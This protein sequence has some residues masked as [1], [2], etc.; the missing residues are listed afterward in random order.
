MIGIGLKLLLETGSI[1]CLMEE[2]V[3]FDGM[4]YNT[5]VSLLLRV[6]GT[7]AV[8]NGSALGVMTRE[9]KICILATTSQETLFMYDEA[10]D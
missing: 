4:V 7:V 3:I 10:G 1:M 2:I 8:L 6:S 5:G 9:C